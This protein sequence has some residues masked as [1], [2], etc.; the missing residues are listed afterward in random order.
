MA[1]RLFALFRAFLIAPLLMIL[2]GIGLALIAE[3]RDLFPSMRTLSIAPVQ[4]AGEAAAEGFEFLESGE[5]RR[6]RLRREPPPG[7]PEGVPVAVLDCECPDA[8]E[9]MAACREAIEAA[10]PAWLAWEEG[11]RF[12]A[13][14]RAAV[15]E[16]AALPSV[17]RMLALP[18]FA[19]VFAILLSG[20][21]RAWGQDLRRLLAEP[22]LLL[23]GLLLAP[24]LTL[25]IALPPALVFGR[26]VGLPDL[27]GEPGMPEGALA[28]LLPLLL[29]ASMVVIE[30]GCFR[31]YALAAL[32]KRF[33]ARAAIVLSSLPFGLLHGLQALTNLAPEGLAMG[34]PGTPLVAALAAVLSFGGALV[35]AWLRLATGGLIA[36]ILAHL[37]HNLLASTAFELLRPLFA[38]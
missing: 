10:R 2:G 28:T 22:R 15:E 6:C 32:L 24:L 1:G 26:E 25:A 4:V 38:P 17:W 34:A 35:F 3:G 37:A 30:E 7:A 5:R 36:P 19:L 14:T 9:R 23:L 20:G 16:P 13:H 11:A 18:V 29:M 12:V 33:G 21:P 8:F 27:K 31:G